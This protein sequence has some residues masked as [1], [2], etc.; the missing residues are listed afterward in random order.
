MGNCTSCF[1]LEP[2]PKPKTAK[3]IHVHGN[4]RHFKVPITAAELM[5]E[6]PGHVICPVENL[7]RTRRFEAMKA[8]ED[9]LAGKLYMLVSTNRV[10][11]LLSESEMKLVESV[12][13]K[14]RAKRRGSKILPD[15]TPQEVD[16]TCEESGDPIRFMGGDDTGLP[17]YRLRQ[18]RPALDPIVEGV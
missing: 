4:L 8:D 15:V 16:E 12:C 6:E 1:Y 5:L 7:R 13:E 14:R 3:L 10:H 11:R 17:C 2:K 9:L 18:W